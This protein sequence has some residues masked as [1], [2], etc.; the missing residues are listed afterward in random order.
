MDLSG[1]AAAVRIKYPDGRDFMC[2]P[3]YEVPEIQGREPD[4]RNV[5][6]WDWVQ[7]CAEA[8]VRCESV[9]RTDANGHVGWS[10]EPEV[11]EGGFGTVRA[12]RENKNGRLLTRFVGRVGMVAV[13]IRWKG[14]PGHTHACATDAGERK[15][16]VDYVRLPLREY[17]NVCTCEVLHKVGNRLH[18]TKHTLTYLVDI[19]PVRVRL[20]K[21]AIR[22]V[23]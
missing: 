13:N 20:K 6:R 14:G 4:E 5:T 19:A 17:A 9:I 3:V 23:R 15:T 18:N 1:R 21:G 2:V 8:P 11:G 7:E 10:T 16:R 12:E 22:W